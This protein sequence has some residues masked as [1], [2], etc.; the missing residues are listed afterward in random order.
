MTTGEVRSLHDAAELLEGFHK[1]IAGVLQDAAPMQAAYLEWRGARDLTNDEHDELSDRWGY[2]Q[3]WQAAHELI[4]LL[5]TVDQADGAADG[6][7]ITS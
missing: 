6:L 3:F 5:A 4:A 7:K 2:R 1:V